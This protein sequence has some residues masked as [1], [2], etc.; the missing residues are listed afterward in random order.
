[1]SQSSPGVQPFRKINKLPR[2]RNLFNCF[3]LTLA[4]CPLLCL[5]TA[6]RLGISGEPARKDPV[7]VDEKTEAVIK[8]ALK[9]LASKQSPNGAWA[10]SSEEQQHPIAM[11]GYTLMAFQA[12]GQLPGEGEY[13]RN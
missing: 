11:T 3:P 7:V 9:Y 10:V 2:F 8:G 1:M 6:A 12:A 5:L 13:G 4:L